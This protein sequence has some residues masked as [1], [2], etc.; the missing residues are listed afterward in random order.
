[1]VELSF[2]GWSCGGWSCGGWRPVRL[3]A[4]LAGG[5]ALAS[6]GAFGG[7][8]DPAG[9]TAESTGGYVGSER[10]AA[11]HIQ[12]A[13]NWAHTAHA[14]PA[15]LNFPDGHGPERSDGH[16]GAK[17][18]AEGCETCH[19]PGA[20]H[21]IRPDKPSTIIRFSSTSTQA[22][23][24]QNAQ[25]MACHKGGQRMHWP[26]S[27]HETHDVA[28]SDCHNPMARVSRRGLLANRSI[29]ETCFNCHQQQRAEF[30]RRSHMPLPEGKIACTDC[31]NPHGGITDPMLNTVRLNDTCF[32]CHAEKRGPFIWEHAPVR[33]DCTNCHRPH[34]SNHDMLLNAPRP[35]LC[36]QC[37]SQLGHPGDLLGRGNLAG[38]VR[39]DAR[40]IGRS[41]SNCHANVHGSN[42]P[43][44]LKFTR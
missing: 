7:A 41:C 38:G 13:E 30:D 22:V 26:N 36:Q 12:A 3:A 44:G 39:P 29:N 27:A 9:S 18:R 28:C 19:G 25:C 24:E 17:S 21:V 43:S 23:P 40:L 20:E 35:L 6:P 31:H 33:E 15:S 34:G 37:H 1:M 5:L 42:H 16:S 32:E 8:G 2:G 4:A 10:C 11:C 14:G